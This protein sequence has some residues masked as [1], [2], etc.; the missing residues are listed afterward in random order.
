MSASG[1]D[2]VGSLL[3]IPGVPI[4]YISQHQYSIERLPEATIG[5][6]NDFC[7]TLQIIGDCSSFVVVLFCFIVMTLI[8]SSTLCCHQ[9]VMFW[10]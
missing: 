3:Q 1:L 7:V 8:V 6:G 9:I 2:S 10:L 4:M 5:G